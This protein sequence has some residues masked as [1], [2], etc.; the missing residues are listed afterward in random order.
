MIVAYLAK[1]PKEFI[2]IN[3][4]F[5]VFSLTKANP[6]SILENETIVYSGEAYLCWY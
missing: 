1:S 4:T 3:I 2:K 5:I 6:S